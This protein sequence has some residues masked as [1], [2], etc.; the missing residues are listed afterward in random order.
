MPGAAMPKNR[1]QHPEDVEWHVDAAVKYYESLFGQK[2]AGMWP[3]EGS[4]S[5]DIIPILARHG[6]KWLATDEEILAE[7]LGIPD[8]T[9]DSY[10]LISS[11]QLY[12]GYNYQKKDFQMALFFRDHALSDNIGFVYSGWDAEKAADDFLSKLWAIH[13]YV[14][15]KQ[16]ANPVVPII[17]DG[18]NAWE[19][20][21]NDGHDF[22][23]ALY[24]KIESSQCLETITF[25]QYLNEKPALGELKKIFPG[26]W[27]SHNFAVWI[28]HAEDNKAWDMVYKTRDEFMAFKKNNPN[29][30]KEKLELAW[31]E[32]MISEG[33]DWCWWFGEDHV[34][35]NNDDFD[36]LFRAHLANVYRLTDREP[37]SDIYLPVRSS[38]IDAHFFKPVDFIKPIIDGRLTHYYE[39]QQAGYFDCAKAGSTMHKAER[40]LFGIWFGF[41]DKNL[42]FRIDPAVTITRKRFESFIFSFEFLDSLK[43]IVDITPHVGLADLNEK[44]SSEIKCAY[45]DF[46]EI[47]MPL[48]LF[49]AMKNTTLLTRLTI[50]EDG[51]VLEVWPPSD[52]LKIELPN[53]HDIPWT[54]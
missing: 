13:E 49:A 17:L 14:L 10:S 24:R 12:R 25:N 36:R 41:D 8:R 33:S 35:P 43:L 23:E 11:G 32:L 37:P 26:S 4:V 20:Y 3:S 2:P 19:Y 44:I 40:M 42:Y 15:K 18:E 28:G 48:S 39:W 29:F 52:A 34:G 51:K 46:L 5:E 27:I 50:K 31:K 16:I 9:D 1:F 54:V 21:Q 6:I 38:F 47:S 30:D 45:K 53:P 7:S 22:L